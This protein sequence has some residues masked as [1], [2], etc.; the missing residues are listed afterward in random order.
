MKKIINISYRG[1]NYRIGWFQGTSD[2]ALRET[3]KETLRM[4]PDSCVVLKDNNSIIYAI[5]QHLP[6]QVHLI[7]E[8]R[9][10]DNFVVLDDKSSNKSGS[11]NSNATA[12]SNT[13]RGEL[14]KF[15]RINAHLA[16]E[17]TWLA[18][19]RTA[20]STLSCA[21]AFLSLSNSSTYE[22]V[23]YI[24]GSL[25]CLSVLF[26]YYTGWLRYNRVKLIL[27]LSYSEMKNTFDRVG[28]HWIAKSL[29]FLFVCTAV[30]YWVGVFIDIR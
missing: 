5:N 25:F 12:A 27:G 15:E 14:L 29:G 9:T 24:L 28:V 6:D 2:I 4:P 21:F 22:V 13:F 19:V 3:I 16:N 10:P 7:A 1:E 18:W 17:R 11:S 30:I 8:L 20:L 26:V 23:V